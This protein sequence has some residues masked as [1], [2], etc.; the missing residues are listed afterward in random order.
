MSNKYIVTGAAGFIGSNIVKSLNDRGEEDILVV[1]EFQSGDKTGNLEG[2]KCSGTLDKDQFRSRI[3]ENAIDSGT[4]LFH[5][6]ACSS[7]T[8]TDE[9]FLQDN[10]YLYTRDLCEWS[11]KND[12]RFVYASSAAT[13]GDGGKGYSDADEV[14]P[15]LEPLNLYGAS[16]QQFD[17][18]ALGEGLLSQIVG[19]KYFNVYGPREDHK[20]DMRS[21]I[22]KAY[23]QI[24]ETG[25][26]KLF[27]SYR[28]E[29]KDG[30]QLRDFVYVKDAVDVTLY[31][32]DNSTPGGLYNCGTGEAR[33]WKD[34]VTAIF[35]AMEREP[36]I[37]YI[38]MPEQIREKYQYETQAETA[39]LRTAW[40]RSTLHIARRRCAR[41]CP[42]LPY[43]EVVETSKQPPAGRFRVFVCY[44]QFHSK[45]FKSNFTV[46]SS[47]AG[48]VV[49]SRSKIRQRGLPG[50]F[51][52]QPKKF[53]HFVRNPS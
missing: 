13:Y 34:L 19:L 42:E 17:R 37:E 50:L 14:T 12:V 1:D 9:A 15:T 22:N 18:W 33:T 5:M 43:K 7:T 16:K 21:V 51:G 23:G 47:P 30:E 48:G 52:S 20:G 40:F 27:K 38:E 26:V 32:G 4:A 8:E 25:R 46:L 45:R 3:K 36:Q 10:N 6:G 11:L 35:Q 2:L 39:K 44:K 31:F 53:H 41:L 28:P 29:Y 24:S 49:D